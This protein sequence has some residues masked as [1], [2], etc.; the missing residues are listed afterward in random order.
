M[1]FV[2]GPWGEGS[3]DLHI[4]VKTM[5][6]SK[7]AAKARALGQDISDKELCIVVT[8]EVSLHLLRQSA[9]PVPDQQAE[10]PGGGSP[11]SCRQKRSC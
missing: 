5:A 3:K 1:G 8:Q 9:E 6:D 2:V 4:L 7:V 11:G 10:L